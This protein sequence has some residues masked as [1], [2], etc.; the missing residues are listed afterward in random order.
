MCYFLNNLYCKSSIISMIESIMNGKSCMGEGNPLGVADIF[1]EFTNKKKAEI[2]NLVKAGYIKSNS[3]AQEISISSLIDV[4]ENGKEL[5][6][7]YYRFSCQNTALKLGLILR[8]H[9][10]EL[11]SFLALTVSIIALF[12]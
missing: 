3:K 2:I 9:F 10:S 1:N 8:K 11:V 7:D 5:Y 4:T 12:K 6:E